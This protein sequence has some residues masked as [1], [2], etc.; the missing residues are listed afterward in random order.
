MNKVADTWNLENKQEYMA[1]VFQKWVIDALVQKLK[2]WII[3]KRVKHLTV[4]GGVAANKYLRASIAQLDISSSIVDLKFSGDNAAMIA[5]YASRQ[6]WEI[7]CVQDE[8]SA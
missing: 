8:Y 3:K 1:T 2:Y 4:A 6:L 5:Y 7:Y